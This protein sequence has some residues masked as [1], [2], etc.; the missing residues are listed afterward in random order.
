MFLK[1]YRPK[2]SAALKGSEGKKL[3]QRLELAYPHISVDLLMP[4]KA[5]LTQIKILTHGGV[6]SMV[7][8]V[9]KLPMFF[10]LDGGQL[11]PTLYTLWTVK[12]ILPYFTTHEGVLPKLTNGADLMLPGVV[13]LGVGLSMYGHYKKG[14]LIA[15]NLTN[16]SSAVGVGR[17]ARSSDELYMCGGH[18]VAVNMLH[19]FG[20]KLWSHEPSLVQQIP[21]L[22]TKSLTTEDFPALGAEPQRKTTPKVDAPTVTTE[23]ETFATAD[24]PEDW[25]DSTAALTL[26]N[27]E[28]TLPDT[29][30]Q[31]ISQETILKNAFLSALKNNGK[32]LPLPLLTS[33]FYRLYVVTEAAEQIDLKK[34][35]YKKL[36]NF[37]A[38][39][40]D[41]GFI[42]VREESKGVDKIISVDLEHPDVVNFITDV[43]A[44][45]ANSGASET[46]L[47]HSE[48]KEMYIVSDITA[49]FF[50]KL[51]YKRGEGIPVAQ[52]K[53]IVREY[54]SKNG[55]L[56]VQTKL[57]RPDETLAELFGHQRAGTLS[58]ICSLITSKMEHAY[59]MCSGKD[60][61]GKPL[62]QMSLA[63]RSGNKKVTLVSNIEA[64][65]IIL[66]EF[67][68]LCKQGAAA[69]T[70][71]VKLPHQKHEQLQIQG[72][73]VRFIFTLLT[74]TYKVPPKCIL[75]LELAKDGK[76]N[77]RK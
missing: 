71:I 2:S 13:P 37:L 69:S 34:T 74:E 46:P 32:K 61:S 72:N 68:K 33:N 63:T 35:R 40:V 48:L 62:I 50:T 16:N 14:Q 31:E 17:L 64:Y 20:D 42:V 36:S 8:C 1:P 9:D 28:S 77:K 57:V 6:Q 19:L 58:E 12:D 21:L 10:E 3:R 51:N 29:L 22:K 55:L 7:Y 27:E 49:A 65:G 75:G 18:G 25:E 52:I 67:I 44:N 66:S 43:K 15:V 76:K 59:Q 60:T 54:V 38:E 23:S 24:V 4:A 56:D 26:E 53:K 45:D 47:F 73:Q 70:T 30:T 11:V 5:A 39:M 41:Q